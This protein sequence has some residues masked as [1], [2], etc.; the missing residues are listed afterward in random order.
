MVLRT[1]TA[2][3][4]FFKGGGG[5]GAVSV[6]HFAKQVREIWRAAEQDDPYADLFLLRIYDALTNTRR[7]IRQTIK[8]YRDY[9]AKEVSFDWDL[10]LSKAG[11]PVRLYFNSS[12]GYMAANLIADLDELV[13]LLYATKKLGVML[14]KPI[15]ELIAESTNKI[16]TVLQW[17][18]QWRKTEI[19]REDVRQQNE[20]AKQAK[21]FMGDIHEQILSGKLRSPYAPFKKSKTSPTT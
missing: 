10:Q 7:D 2:R 11:E 12:Y 5:K 16:K 19:T 9:L 8:Y 21:I 15:A 6:L 14:D 18:Q 13:C 20:K 4:Y 1:S 17:P 3:Y